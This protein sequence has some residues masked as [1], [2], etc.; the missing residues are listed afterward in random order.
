MNNQS[1]LKLDSTS[2]SHDKKGLWSVVCDLWSSM[3]IRD[4]FILFILSLIPL[5]WFK[6][7]CFIASGDVAQYLDISNLMRFF[8]WAWS[9]RIAAGEPCLHTTFSLPIGYFWLILK[10]LGVHMISIEKLWVFMTFFASAV[11]MYIFVRGFIKDNKSC[12]PLFAGIFYTYN[13]FLVVAPLI[14][15][16]NLA[17]LY[18]FGPL[19]LSFWSRGLA[20][21][22]N[23]KRYGYAALCALSSMLYTHTNVNMPHVAAFFVI[24][25][26]LTIYHFIFTS[27]KILGDISFILVSGLLYVSV[28][29]WWIVGSFYQMVQISDVVQS[30]RSGWH[31]LG[32][33]HLNDAFRL[34]GFWA[35]DH[36]HLDLYYF[37]FHQHYDSWGMLLVS[38]GIIMLAIMAIVM[39][40][41]QAL[42]PALLL[43]CGLFLVKGA[44][45]PGGGLYEYFWK[46]IYGLWVF[47]EPWSKFTHINVFALSLL[48][49]ISVNAIYDKIINWS[50]SCDDSRGA[51]VFQHVKRS[52]VMT[53]PLMIVSMVLLN[54]YPAVTGEIIWDQ[55]NMNIRS[56]H[57]KVPEYWPRLGKW[58]EDNDQYARVFLLPK[59]GYAKAAYDWESGFTSATTAAISFLPNQLAYWTDFPITRA[60]GLF[61]K[62]IPIIYKNKGMHAA[63]YLRLLGVKYILQQ[64]DISWQFT[65][66]DAIPHKKITSILNNMEGIKPLM[67]FGKLDLY[68]IDSA[69]PIIYAADT[70]TF[71]NDKEKDVFSIN[72]ADLLSAPFV[73]GKQPNMTQGDT[74]KSFNPIKKIV[75]INPVKYVVN[76]KAQKPYWIVFNESFNP[77]WQARISMSENMS[78]M[79][80]SV[81]RDMIFYGSTSS[82][83]KR[84]EM[85]NGFANGWYINQTGQYS[86]VIEYIPQGYYEVGK[87]IS[88]V[89]GIVC[90]FFMFQMICARSAKK[91]L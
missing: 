80:G 78:I 54:C 14:V 33:T 22:S 28:N 41:R 51:R 15:Q 23:K 89:C 17:P 8:P 56:M 9:E 61:N 52:I 59:T 45:G 83:A 2:Q 39:K 40:K 91:I 3:N 12:A 60:H 48:F 77:G 38:Y 87:I 82:I 7:G 67:T 63:D 25:I 4:I 55:Y 90:L 47:R 35:W 57:V 84:H 11:S 79:R 24:V 26:V 30:T 62:V 16:Y 21:E 20:S 69:L 46:N 86:V 50:R 68:E 74:A 44:N 27:K 19:T 31:L 65:Y 72:K 81:L 36:K 53:F 76:V 5:F 42:F 37:P 71:I 64:N 49:G 73:F 29:I 1:N 43:V 13:L 70:M 34:L 6:E 58:F 88:W 10:K 32:A 18:M 75:R 66:D 85:I